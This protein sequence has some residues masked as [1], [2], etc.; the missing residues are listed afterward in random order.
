MNPYIKSIPMLLILSIITCGLY[1]FYVQYIQMKAVNEMIGVNKYSFAKWF[2]LLIVTCSLYHIYHE[3]IMSHDI[4]Q[5]IKVDP[6]LPV[7][8]LLLSIFGLSIVA[9][10]ICQQHIN[11]YYSKI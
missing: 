1:S 3:Y 9:D 4:E 8:C 10:A 2:I 11:E 6:N 7:I 5:H